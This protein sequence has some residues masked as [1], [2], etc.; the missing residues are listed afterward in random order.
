MGGLLP[1]PKQLQQ[2]CVDS[3]KTA[4]TFF[5]FI[6]TLAIKHGTVCFLFSTASPYQDIVDSATS[7]LLMAQDWTKTFEIIDKVNSDPKCSVD[8][9][10]ALKRRIT[11]KNT[12][13]VIRTLQLIDALI[14]NCTV[15][16]HKAMSD[17][18]ILS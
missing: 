18:G 8:I 7:E 9:V 11:S 5:M 17:N 1:F 16:L 2:L 3:S 6:D 15:E 10:N 4:I 14:K 12:I 13:V